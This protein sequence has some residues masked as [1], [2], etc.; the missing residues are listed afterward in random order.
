MKVSISGVCERDMDLFLIE[1]LVADH[2]LN[3]ASQPVKFL[4]DEGKIA[5]YAVGS[6]IDRFQ[7]TCPNP[8]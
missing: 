5:V 2:A 1:E 7:S 3:L 6:S 4:R 8:P